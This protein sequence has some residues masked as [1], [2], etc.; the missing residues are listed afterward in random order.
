M[1]KSL[2]YDYKY[3]KQVEGQLFSRKGVL[4]P[5]E[6]FD[7]DCGQRDSVAGNFPMPSQGKAVVVAGS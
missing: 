3:S 2:S 7:L 4:Q 1:K 6:P 5:M